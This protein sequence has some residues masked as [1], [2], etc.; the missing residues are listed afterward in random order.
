VI[1]LAARTFADRWQLFAGTVLAVTAGVAIVHAGMTIILGVESAKPPAGGTAE[2]AESFRQT[3]SGASTLTGM[4]VML[5]AFLTIF[6]VGSTFGFAVDQRRRDLAILRLGGVTARQVR[7]LLLM[8]ACVAALLGAVA[9]ALLGSGLTI[10]QRALLAWLGTFPKDLATPMQPA[11]LA[12]DVIAALVVCSAGAWG[13]ARRSTKLTPLDALRRTGDEQRVMTVRRWIVAGAA[14]ALT[15]VQ[16]FFSATAGGILIPLLLGLGIVITASVAMSRLSPLLVPGLAQLLT[17]WAR[18]S[19][20]AD[21]AVA[22]LR[23]AVRRT[24]SCA[25]PMIVLVSLVM[26]LQGILDTQTRAVAVE[27]TTLLDADLIATGEHIDL[28]TVDG[29]DGVALAAPETVVPLAVHLTHDGTTTTGPGTVVAVDPD[30]FRATHLQ[31]PEAG[32]LDHFDRDS[33]VFGPGLDATMVRDRYDRIVLD[34]DGKRIAL[35]E[36]ARM[37]ETLAGVDGFYVDRSAMP[38]VLLDRATS[39][40]VQLGPGADPAAVKKGLKAAGATTVQTP[41]ESTRGQDSATEAE[42][43]AVMAAIVGLGSLYSLISVLSTLAISIGQRRGELA[44]LSL[45]GLTRRQIQQATVLEALAATS[46]GL[47][48]GAISAILALVGLW[49][50]T[51]RIYGTPVIAIPWTLLA[52]ITVLTATLTILTAMVATRSATKVFAIRALGAQ[53]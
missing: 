24:A 27:A 41:A 48:L 2:Q 16:T 10:V 51:Y 7:R 19:P 15:V 37:S 4:T 8:E 12:L 14:L 3:A 52:A 31:R 39:V 6:V 49:A 23:D 1:R 45:S 29:I 47:V 20:V 34:I 28:T 21:L 35:S 17:P 32:D 44:T 5:G 13:A 42:N 50:A 26:G 40:L 30:A 25:A 46:I 11:V 43:R 9:G 33:I 22:N 38:D 53:E 36:A 18:R